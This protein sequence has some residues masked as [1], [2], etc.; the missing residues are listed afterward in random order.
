MEQ[1]LLYRKIGLLIKILTGNLDQV[2]NVLESTRIETIP[3]EKIGFVYSQQNARKEV[4]AFLKWVLTDG[5]R[6]NHEKGFLNLTKDA[7][8]EQENRLSSKLLS[9]K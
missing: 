6:F 5:Q 9:L 2:I 7:L 1:F 4:T 8:V 3:V